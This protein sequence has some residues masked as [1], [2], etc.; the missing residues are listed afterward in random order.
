[1]RFYSFTNMYLSPIQKGIQTAHAVHDMFVKYHDSLRENTH[2]GEWALY[3]QW[4]HEHKTIV[5]LDGGNSA[6]LGNLFSQLD[7]FT[8]GYP[9]VKFHEDDVSLNGALTCVGI[10]LD[11]KMIELVKMSRD[12]AWN[13]PKGFCTNDEIAVA[14]LVSQYHLAR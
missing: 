4:A 11:E 1:M 8:H 13:L 10:I 2:D 5:V 7:T 6:E 3:E 12:D 14:K 9:Y